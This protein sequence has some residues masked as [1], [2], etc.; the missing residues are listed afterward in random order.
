MAHRFFNR[1]ARAIRK[2]KPTSTDSTAAAP[3]GVFGTTPGVGTLLDGRYRLE[4]EIGR[5]GM[6]IVYRAHDIAEQREVA[7]KV[8][9]SETANALT[10]QQFLQEADIMSRLLH[11]HLVSVYQVGMAETGA[12][13]PSPFIVM[14][15][16]HGTSLDEMYGFTFSRILDIGKQICEA[17]EYVHRQG[18][19][20]GDLKPGN[21]LIEK[22]GFQYVA[23]LADF[24]LARP[25]DTVS[26]ATESNRAGTLFYLAPEIIVGG[27]ADICSD[28]YALGATLY[29]MITGRVP[30]SDFEEG[31]ILAQ[32]LEAPVPPP[33]ESRADVP[34][35]L[36]AIVLCLLAKK[37]EDRFASAQ[38]VHQ[39]LEQI[40]I[41][42]EGGAARNNL[43]EHLTECNGC[44]DD[45]EAV[46]Q[47]LESSPLVTLLGN[48]RSVALAIGSQ[49]ADQFSDGVWWVDLE[50]AS[51]P[52]RVLETVSSE[53]G[54][55][56]DPQ[57]SLTVSLIEHLRE[58]DVLLI[59]NHC[60]GVRLAC[61]QLVETIL[62][63]CPDVRILTTS[64]QAFDIPLER[65]HFV[66]D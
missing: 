49:L 48:S 44:G 51:D 32:H 36:E 18:L 45:L 22:R 34:P 13:E 42:H 56:P 12:Q 43:P 20:Y 39:A 50:S 7:I 11:P 23:K 15:L 55:R 5:G 9:N 25:R 33:S 17:L 35:A 52:V 53:L 59:F 40:T 6:G 26:S 29:E 8:I 60:D 21:V 27:Q 30:F 66:A 57:R 37:P 3:A 47:L 10:R 58:Q 65:C 4:A 28:L 24:G 46:K 64:D 19:V 1:L 38:K 63:T 16:V 61:A 31:A 14:E 2:D 62:H 54:I 41:T